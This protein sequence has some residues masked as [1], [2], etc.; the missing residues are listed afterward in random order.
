MAIFYDYVLG[1]SSVEFEELCGRSRRLA[2]GAASRHN[3]E[4]GDIPQPI[5]HLF[6]VPEAV[7]LTEIMRSISEAESSLRRMRNGYPDP[8]GKA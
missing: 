2:A 7:D 3:K 1:L 4:V 8:T 5:R 6:G